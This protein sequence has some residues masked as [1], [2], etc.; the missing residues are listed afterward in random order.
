M[1]LRIKGWDGPEPDDQALVEAFRAGS[2]SA[3]EAIFAKTAPR[4][5]VQARRRLGSSAEAEDAVQETFERALRGLDRF[6]IQGDFRMGAWLARIL[7]NV[8]HDRSAHLAV[9]RRAGE[10]VAG[11]GGSDTPD[12]ADA[13]VERPLSAEMRRALDELPAAYRSA[14]WLRAVE[15]LDYG[16]V[17]RCTGT[18]EDNA[19]ARVHRARQALRRRLGSVGSALGVAVGPV[20]LAWGRRS[21]TPSAT[22]ASA[23][24]SFSTP[25]TMVGQVLA[26]PSTQA[27][28]TAGGGPKGT[29]L[30]SALT[31]MVSLAPGGLVLGTAGGTGHPSRPDTAAAVPATVATPPPPTAGA[32]AGSP[33]L[34]WPALPPTAPPILAPSMA[35]ASPLP[36][37][38]PG[39]PKS[40]AVIGAAS[41]ASA[42]KRVDTG[43]GADI[44]T[45]AG[46]GS[47]GGSLVSVAN[48]SSVAISSA[49]STEPTSATGPPPALSTSTVLAAPGSDP[50][51][52][53]E[54][55]GCSSQGS[56]P[57]SAGGGPGCSPAGTPAPS[58]S[59]TTVAPSGA[60][61]FLD[62]PQPASPDVGS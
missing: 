5:L 37:V 51:P 9:E 61:P 48:P 62:T 28:I 49:P 17:A 39:V 18:T 25:A 32:A 13:V 7:A 16:E 2:A 58:D 11:R 60:T 42:V 38:A 35:A 23:Q 4:L 20:A 29:V 54:T 30:I 24:A 47:G 34:P 19:R 36:A 59:T 44:G 27:A 8:C 43:T 10:R 56:P 1:A 41:D 55:T 22:T 3:F 31:A 21:R 52:G 46:T 12:L 14:L 45:G 26:Q 6:G 53:A 15:D 40:T 50:V 57:A 33:A